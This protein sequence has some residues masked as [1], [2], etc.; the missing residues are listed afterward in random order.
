[1]AL[2]MSTDWRGWYG[3]GEHPR[4]PRAAINN[5]DCRAVSKVQGIAKTCCQPACGSAVE[6][7]S[8]TTAYYKNKPCPVSRNGLS[9]VYNQNESGSRCEGSVDGAVLMRLAFTG[10]LPLP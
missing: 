8:N 6:H 1:M 7:L 4:I 9:R 2:R 10:F 5:E 3:A